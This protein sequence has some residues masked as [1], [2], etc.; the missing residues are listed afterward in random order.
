VDHEHNWTDPFGA[1]RDIGYPALCNA[2]MPPE[3]QRT[4]TS[5]N[6]RHGFDIRGLPELA[7]QPSAAPGYNAEAAKA[8]WSVV[9][10][11]LK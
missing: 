11:F 10:D 7:A 3:K 6:A 8:P 5:P 9:L 4:I 1:L 2:V